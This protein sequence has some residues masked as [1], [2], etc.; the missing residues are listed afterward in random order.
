MQKEYTELTDKLLDDNLTIYFDTEKDKVYIVQSV[1]GKIKEDIVHD[2]KKTSIQKGHLMH[3][4]TDETRKKVLKIYNLKDK[5][6]YE[7]IS[8]EENNIKDLEPDTYQPYFTLATMISLII[9]LSGE[10]ITQYSFTDFFSICAA[11]CVCAYAMYLFVNLVKRRRLKALLVTKEKLDEYEKTKQTRKYGC[12]FKGYLII[13]AIT[14][15]I[16]SIHLYIFSSQIEISQNSF[17]FFLWLYF[18]FWFCSTIFIIYMGVYLMSLFES[19]SAGCIYFLLILALPIYFYNLNSDMKEDY[20]FHTKKQLA[21]SPINFPENI[22]NTD[23]Q[24]FIDAA[25]NYGNSEQRCFYFDLQWSIRHSKDQMEKEKYQL[26]EKRFLQSNS[27]LHTQQILAYKLHE[28]LLADTSRDSI[29]HYFKELHPGNI[30]NTDI[31][32]ERISRTIN[33][34]TATPKQERNIAS[35][36]SSGKRRHGLDPRPLSQ[37]IVNSTCFSM[38]EKIIMIEYI[39]NCFMELA[40]YNRCPE[41]VIQEFK[42]KVF[43]EAESN[44][45]I[46][47]IEESSRSGSSY[48]EEKI[49]ELMKQMRESNPNWVAIYTPKNW[50]EF[51]L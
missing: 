23:G 41:T 24:A 11:S 20:Y 46:S 38:D 5:H 13:L 6:R 8:M 2:F 40:T 44:Y 48:I 15:I 37:A 45:H 16:I 12:A 7:V 9:F 26:L 43:D 35:G 34:V 51:S 1:D 22:M 47:E 29:L 21:E 27:R 39:I 19:E 33:L 30:Y 31:Y 10:P 3:E 42:T 49:N 50:K 32:F 25:R 17:S 18:P 4:I 28:A 14:F 36:S